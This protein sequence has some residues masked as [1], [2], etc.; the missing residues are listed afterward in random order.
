VLRSQRNIHEQGLDVV[1]QRAEITR[2]LLGLMR[3]INQRRH[4]G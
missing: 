2:A 3:A 4:G 1:S